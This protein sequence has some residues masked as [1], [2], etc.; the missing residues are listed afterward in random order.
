MVLHEWFPL[1][2]INKNVLVNVFKMMSVLA[3]SKKCMYRLVLQI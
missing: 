1:K 3:Q 2:G